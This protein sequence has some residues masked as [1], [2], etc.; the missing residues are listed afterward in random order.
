MPR[1]LSPCRNH[2]RFHGVPHERR[3]TSPT[4]RPG[5]THPAR[6]R[7]MP[8]LPTGRRHARRLETRPAR[9]LAP[10]PTRHRRHARRARNRVPLTARPDRHLHRFRQ[11]RLQPVR[12]PDGVR[13]RPDPR[14]NARRD[15]GRDRPRP[16]PRPQACAHRRA[17][18][19]GT[20]DDRRRRAQGRGRPLRIGRTTL[21]G[22]LANDENADPRNRSDVSREALEEPSDVPRAAA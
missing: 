11:A 15:A 10:P 9:P 8:G 5:A 4:R 22:H 2:V 14:T 17:I 16:P 7:E 1:W 3:P 21:Y 19:S 13:P 20:R 18:A 6:A 12:S